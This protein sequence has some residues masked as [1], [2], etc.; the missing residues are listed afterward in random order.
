MTQRFQLDGAEAVGSSPQEFGAFFKA[1]IVKW[2]R[3]VQSAGM[4]AD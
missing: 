3:I 4:R 1:E 2:T